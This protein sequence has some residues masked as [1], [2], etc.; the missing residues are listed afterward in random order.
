MRNYRHIF[1]AMLIAAAAV[2]FMSVPAQAKTRYEIKTE[3]TYSI[4]PGGEEFLDS[5]TVFSYNK[6]GLV[7]KES[8]KSGDIA[9]VKTYAYN[10][11]DEVKKYLE[12]ENGKETSRYDYTFNKNGDVT[13]SLHYE[14]KKL[15]GKTIFKYNKKKL[16]STTFYEGKKITNIETNTFDSKGRVKKAVTKDAKGKVISTSTITYKT[17]GSKITQQTVKTKDADGTSTVV[18]NYYSNGQIKSFTFKT[19]DGGS[20]A[21]YDKNGNKLKETYQS[22]N[23]KEV[24]TYKNGWIQKSEHTMDGKKSVYT[25]K[26]T[27]DAKTK[28]PKVQTQYNGKEAIRRTEYTY[29]VIK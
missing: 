18:Y 10:A 13:K 19:K 7:T 8:F 4:L 3:K 21:A 12:K 1:G 26:Y 28:Q 29:T 14:N 11:N 2:L 9:T 16:L 24:S 6:K 15:V 17:S 22:K 20:S 25:Y 27:L 5:T 23:F